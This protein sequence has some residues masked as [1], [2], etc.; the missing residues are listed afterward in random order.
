MN[1]YPNTIPSSCNTTPSSCNSS[2]IVV[3]ES[4]LKKLTYNQNILIKALANKPEGILSRRL[5][6]L[7]GIS[8]KSDL[9]N[10]KL[11]TLLAAEGIEIHTERSSCK[12]WLWKIRVIE[13]MEEETT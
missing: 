2:P 3:S 6:H 7:T 4:T 9:C 11:R 10:L 5:A 8:N 13:K 1:I 12:Q